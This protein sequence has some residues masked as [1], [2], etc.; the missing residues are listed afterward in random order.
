ML[1]IIIIYPTLWNS[2]HP[3][4]IA[5]DIVNKI[6]FRKSVNKVKLKANSQVDRIHIWKDY[7]SKLLSSNI[8]HSVQKIKAI[9]EDDLQ[10]KIGSFNMNQLAL[11][12]NNIKL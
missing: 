4:D 1:S 10:I 9:R 6:G 3:T 12:L 7:F 5:W 11:V 2:F 8:P